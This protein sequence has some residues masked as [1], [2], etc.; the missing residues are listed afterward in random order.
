[1]IPFQSYKINERTQQLNTF[2]RYFQSIK[3]QIPNLKIL[4]A[5]QDWSSSGVNH[6]KHPIAERN[7]PEL[8]SIH[9]PK[10]NRGILLNTAISLIQNTANHIITHDVDLLPITKRTI[11]L[12]SKTPNDNEA[13]HIAAGWGRYTSADY[14]GGILSMNPTT[15]NTVNG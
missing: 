10:F 15:W 3:D 9:T 4:I 14:V 6:I 5:E 11:Q 2:L 8:S 12:Y 13:I 1:V 7:H